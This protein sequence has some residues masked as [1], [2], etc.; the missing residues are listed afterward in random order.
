[1]LL[2]LAA[3]QAVAMAVVQI[4]YYDGYETIINARF[5]VGDSPSY[6]PIRFPAMAALAAPAEAVRAAL[7][8]HPL[9]VRP[10]HVASGLLHILYLLGSYALLVRCCGPGWPM[11]VAFVA[12]VPTYL[13]FTYAPFLSHDLAP[14]AALLWMLVLADAQLRK[15]RAW[16]WLAL[17]ALGAIS[18]LVKPAFGVFWPALLAAFALASLSEPASARRALLRPGASLLAAAAAS[19]LCFWIVLAAVLGETA[20]AD[21]AFW[22]R[23]YDQVSNMAGQISDRQV[24]LWWIYLRN[25]PAFGLLA[26]IG[27]VPGLWLGLRGNRL[28]RATALCWIACV[29][30]VQALPR[31]EVRYLAFLA[32]LSALLLVAPVRAAFER[33]RAARIALVGVLALSWLPLWPY[34]PA[35]A[36]LDLFGAPY[37]RDGLRWFLE[38]L[39]E[40]PR[41]PHVALYADKVLSLVP[42]AQGPLAGD[43][44]HQVFQ[45]GPHHLRLLFGF[46]QATRV[47][48]PE[49]LARVPGFAPDSIVVWAQA[50][51]LYGNPSWRGLPPVDQPG[52]LQWLARGVAH[53]LSP[54]GTADGGTFDALEGPS[55]K[56]SFHGEPAELLL[57]TAWAAQAEGKLRELRLGVQPPGK[58]RIDFHRLRAESA[59]RYRVEG[60]PKLDGATLWLT[61]LRTERT[62]V[63]GHRP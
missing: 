32:P 7:S 6:I 21:T 33:G 17:V 61:A 55:A 63:G 40:S 43:P 51:R 20:Y 60:A 26:A 47:G 44:F 2:A 9:D 13:F 52:H 4:E 5:L 48:S 54:L 25:A 12:A 27:I 15:P 3:W 11:V 10:A 35:R 19:A 23:P 8:L 31:H 41:P 38:P 16:R 28:E 37:D 30:V 58:T 24:S 18:A 34:S 62:L 1:M 50:P 57:E 45:F 22:R 14:G 39:D 29:V 49:Q 42:A 36:A 59:T 53:E 56:L 46:E